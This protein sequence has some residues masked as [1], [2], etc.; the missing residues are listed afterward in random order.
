[1]VMISWR[2]PFGS[3][4]TA[5]PSLDCQAGILQWGWELRSL[6]TSHLILDCF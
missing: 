5:F 4:S 6:S 3:E 2:L 1:M